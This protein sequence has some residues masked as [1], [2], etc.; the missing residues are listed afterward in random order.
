MRSKT[1]NGADRTQLL[2]T[3]T[4]LMSSCESLGFLSSSICNSPAAKASRLSSKSAQTT[5]IGWNGPCQDCT[6]CLNARRSGIQHVTPAELVCETKED[7]LQGQ[8]ALKAD[9]RLLCL[10]FCL[11][12]VASFFSLDC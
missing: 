8:P 5:V 10:S 3:A 4:R 6:Q 1:G 2:Q 11:S 9:S 7:S 12:I